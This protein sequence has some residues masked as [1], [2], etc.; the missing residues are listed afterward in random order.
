MEV[1]S[2][3][4]EDNDSSDYMPSEDARSDD[5]NYV[6]SEDA[7]SEC[8]D[9]C[10][11]MDQQVDHV[12]DSA[13]SDVVPLQDSSSI[14]QGISMNFEKFLNSVKSNTDDDSND[15]S[16]NTVDESDITKDRYHPGL[17][18]RKLRKSGTTRGG[19]PK[20]TN[21]CYNTLQFCGYCSTRVTNFAQHVT[22]VHKDR[23]RVKDI[24]KEEVEVERKR[25]I[26]L[27][28]SGFN[29][30]NNMKSLKQHKGEIILNRRPET[31]DISKYGPCPRCFL[32]MLKKLL[33]RHQKTCPTHP[34]NH[35]PA[36]VI[37]TQSD[38]MSGK[39]STEASPPVVKEVFNI[40]KRDDVGT[41]ARKDDLIVML[42]NMWMDKNI[43]NRLK[44]GKYTSAVMRLN[45]RF[46]LNLRKLAPLQGNPDSSS[47]MSTY[48]APENFNSIVKAALLTASSTMDDDE[49]LGTPSNALKLGFDLKRLISIKLG[50]AVMRKNVEERKDAEELLCLMNVFWG[51]RV[52]KLA[53]VL[54]DERHFNRRIQLPEPQD[55]KK[56]NEHL[57]DRL[58]ELDLTKNNS[59]SNYIAVAEVILAKLLV[60]NRRRT[61]EM[62]A[63]R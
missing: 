2:S 46:L 54:L 25:L 21:R 33:Y 59:Y 37:V 30:M 8:S 11:L 41:L 38:A 26:A 19:Q 24:M 16:R 51:T 13:E 43:G 14:Y 44:R 29:H 56:L 12:S 45:A 1:S 31:L 23:D 35:L 61:G 60:Y 22:R 5:S 36:P 20:K 32:W 48:L 50:L 27:L 34:V 6:P 53:R 7:R 17:Y 9:D 55:I 57:G 42:G 58:N 49:D 18:I 40:M 52:T 47:T 39:I 63:I 3:P 10:R 28:R 62:E 15:S 4:I